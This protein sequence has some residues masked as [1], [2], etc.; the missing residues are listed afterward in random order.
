MLFLFASAP[1]VSQIWTVLP[2]IFKVIFFVPILC[3]IDRFLAPK[4]NFY[5]NFFSSFI[6]GDRG[7]FLPKLKKG[8]KINKI[9]L[10]KSCYLENK[11]IE[12]QNRNR[13][14][15]L[16]IWVKI[17]NIHFYSFLVSY[18]CC[19]LIFLLSDFRLLHIPLC[20]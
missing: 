13:K 9:F 4:N 15:T 11:S 19:T 8:I 7:P 6:R 3:Q 16:K 14:T 2:Q 12:T 10:C 17:V 5:I 18:F 20:I 1:I